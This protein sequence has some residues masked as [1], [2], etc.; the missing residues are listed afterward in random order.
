MTELKFQ[1][2]EEITKTLEERNDWQEKYN[3]A[4]KDFE[5]SQQRNEEKANE[6][7]RLIKSIAELKISF[8]DEKKAI[9]ESHLNQISGL[10]REKENLVKAAIRDRE[11]AMTGYMNDKEAEIDTKTKEFETKTMILNEKI[12][13]LQESIAKFDDERELW[14]VTQTKLIQEALDEAKRAFDIERQEM[15][16]EVNTL[17]IEIAHKENQI[18]ALSQELA[19]LK[20]DGKEYVNRIRQLGQEVTRL[21]QVIASKDADIARGIAKLKEKDIQFQQDL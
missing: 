11:E 2:E 13:D 9:L 5:L 10:N 4:S 12:K 17:K 7:T 15:Q 1:Y 21:G 19:K 20:E 8:D 6:I 18:T 16:T 14:R 3:R